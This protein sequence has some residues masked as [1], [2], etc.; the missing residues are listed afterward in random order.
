MG[1]RKDSGAPR[2]IELFNAPVPAKKENGF[3]GWWCWLRRMTG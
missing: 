3:L 2:L 1:I